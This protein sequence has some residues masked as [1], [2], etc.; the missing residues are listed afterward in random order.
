MEYLLMI[1]SYLSD[2]INSH[3]APIRDLN[4]IIIEDNLSGEWKIQLTLRINFIS[5]LDPP[6]MH[7]KSDNVETTMSSETDDIIKKLFE[8]FLKKISEKFV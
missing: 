8:S 2:M 1:R 4:D 6:T 7:S 3:K 5:S